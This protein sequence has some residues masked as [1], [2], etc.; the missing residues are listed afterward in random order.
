MTGG[1][2]MA[3]NLGSLGIMGMVATN[4]PVSTV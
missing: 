1:A 4:M 3:A 2:Y